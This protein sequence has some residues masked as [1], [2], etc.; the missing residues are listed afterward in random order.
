MSLNFRDELQAN[1][2]TIFPER[3]VFASQEARSGTTRARGSSKQDRR[4]PPPWPESQHASGGANRCPAWVR[5][6]VGGPHAGM[7]QNQMVASQGQPHW[8]F[9]PSQILG[10]AVRAAGQTTILLSLRQVVPLDEAR[11]DPPTDRRLGQPG[12]TG[13]RIAKHDLGVDRGDA[14][15][16]ALLDYLGVP[17]IG[18][19]TPTWLGM[20]T[21]RPWSRWTVPFSVGHQQRLA[22]S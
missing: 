8:C 14:P 21:A 12:R 6:P 2:G 4:S 18:A 19:R 1:W 3:V 11:V 17:Q 9:K 20:R 5:D 22:I 13:R 16:G 15:A 7:G 10:E